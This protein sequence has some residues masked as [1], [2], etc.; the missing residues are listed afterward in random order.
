MKVHPE[1]GSL[2]DDERSFL[3]YVIQ[4]A[5]GEKQLDQLRMITPAPEAFMLFR[6][7]QDAFDGS[8]SERQV[9][10]SPYML[11]NLAAC[12]WC[13]LETQSRP[14]SIYATER[15]CVFQRTLRGFMRCVFLA[16]GQG[17]VVRQQEG[18][19]YMNC[20]PVPDWMVRRTNPY[21]A[22]RATLRL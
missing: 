7:I 10:V 12:A 2:N 8:G 16:V 3:E 17:T 21:A 20:F 18:G 1:I 11:H 5:G 22:T 13:M 15:D 19:W 6:A 9:T 4:Y 14:D